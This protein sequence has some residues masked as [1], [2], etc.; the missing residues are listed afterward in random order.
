MKGEIDLRYTRAL[1][2]INFDE[3]KCEAEGQGLEP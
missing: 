1:L 3:V 2:I